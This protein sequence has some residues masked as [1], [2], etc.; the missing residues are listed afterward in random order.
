MARLVP[1]ESE[2]NPDG[3]S[4]PPDRPPQNPQNQAIKAKPWTPVT[5]ATGAASSASPWCP[6]QRCPPASRSCPLPPGDAFLEQV[7]ADLFTTT[8]LH[9]I[10]PSSAPAPVW[11]TPQSRDPRFNLFFM[12]NALQRCLWHIRVALGF[13]EWDQIRALALLQKAKH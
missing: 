2:G 13:L 4:V 7:L 3:D 11:V 1:C 5:H 6:R 8:A 12:C 9:L 10:S